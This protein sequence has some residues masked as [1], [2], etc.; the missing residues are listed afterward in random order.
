MF[1]EILDSCKFVTNEAK[2]VKID[3][4]TADELVGNVEL[5]NNTH[6][7]ASSPYGILDWEIK[8]I[9]NFLLIYHAI[10]FS[11]WGDLKWT[12]IDGDSKLDGAFGMIY[13][14]VKKMKEDKNF[15]YFPKLASISYEEFSNV[16]LGNIEI[17]LLGE[18]YNYIID[19]CKTVNR[20]MNGDFYSYIKGITNDIELWEI[21]I[22]NFKAYQDESI[23]NGKTI[24]F[25]KRA[26]LLVSDILHILA[27]K[28][29]QKV[30]YSHLIGCADYK[31]PQVMRSLGL[32]K[33]S[34]RL[35]NLIDCKSEITMGNN[36]EVEIRASMIVGINYIKEKL[37]NGTCTMDI[38]D[39][40]W[41]KGQEQSRE[42]KPYHRTRTTA[43]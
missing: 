33:Y 28:E 17:P 19:T 38:N 5:F 25:Y 39:Y 40:L 13:V 36:Y 4:D 37:D 41:L 24:Y 29:N 22:N 3:F 21:I 42:I 23:Y 43:Y 12:V 30:D 7:L 34:D 9:V 32:L 27:Y 20:K 11:Y 18:R 35:S 15:L 26:Q 31:I 2:D 1:Q 16:F 10:G 8:D 14:L 6:W